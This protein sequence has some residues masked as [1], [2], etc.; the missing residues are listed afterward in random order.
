MPVNELHHFTIQTDDIDKTAAFFRDALGF[1]DGYCPDVDVPF[2]WL[3]CGDRPA[4]HIVGRDAPDGHGSA[5]IDHVAFNCTDYPGVKAR[6]DAFGAK[7]KEQTQP[8]VGVH[9]IF[10]ETP[11]GVWLELVFQIDDYRKSVGETGE[12]A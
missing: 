11:E 10:V 3:Y 5:R 6:L 12:A 8:A 1:T 7:Q 2:I 9:Q 4:V